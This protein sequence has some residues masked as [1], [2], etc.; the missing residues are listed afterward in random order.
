LQ[1]VMTERSAGSSMDVRNAATE[2]APVIQH[3]I[4]LLTAAAREL[5]VPISIN[6]G[7][8]GLAAAPSPTL[9][10]TILGVVGLVVAGVGVLGLRRRTAR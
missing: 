10:V 5:G 1:L 8:A 4:D 7:N 3:H 6:T 9:L 2:A